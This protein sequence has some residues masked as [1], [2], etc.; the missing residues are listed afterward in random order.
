MTFLNGPLNKSLYTQEFELFAKCLLAC[1]KFIQF[2]Y[3]MEDG[4]KQLFGHANNNEIAVNVSKL[5][6]KI[7]Y[8]HLDLSESDSKAF[9]KQYVTDL[10]S[11]LD[12]RGTYE[13]DK[14]G[15]CPKFIGAEY[16]T[17]KDYTGSGYLPVNNLMYKNG[18]N[19]I[20]NNGKIVNAE[21]AAL[22]ILKTAFI[23]SGL[24]KI[25]PDTSQ[26]QMK[27][28]RG[29]HS[30]SPDE[31][32]ARIDSI[33]TPDAFTITPAYMSTSSDIA[34][35]HGFSS[36]VL[37]EFEGLY[38][39]S[40]ECISHFPSEQE[41]LLQPSKIQ[42]LEHHEKTIDKY[43]ERQTVHEFKARVVNP[44]ILHEN[45]PDFK[46]IQVFKNMVDWAEKNNIDTSFITPHNK[47]LYLYDCLCDDELDPGEWVS[48]AV[49]KTLTIAFEKMIDF[50]HSLSEAI[51]QSIESADQDFMP[52]EAFMFSPDLTPF[53]ELA[54]LNCIMI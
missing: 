17:I 38:G 25:M 16:S 39:K 54:E 7:E 51:D 44:L 42:W 28:Y 43:D 45:D 9:F 19:Y 26:A 21:E 4:K 50:G 30:T 23:S 27:S 15:K 20:E 32:Q 14:E 6:K 24:N 40:I 48:C 52:L 22:D 35:A 12:T 10:N 3:Q 11:Y 46:E 33:G 34:V 18:T 53:Q 1:P 2:S 5:L 31:I 41:Y 37:I 8:T 36:G 29:E 47:K 49:E 13:Y